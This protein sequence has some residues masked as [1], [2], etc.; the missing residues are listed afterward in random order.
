MA[1][2]RLTNAVV[3]RVF[4]A[5]TAE[6]SIYKARMFRSGVIALNPGVSALLNGGGK[7]FDLPFWQDVGG[8]S[9][10]V[11]SET[12]AATVNNLVAKQQTF[13]RQ[14][15]LKAW[16]TNDLVK[17]FAGDNPIEA[18]QNMVIEYWADAY[19]RIAMETIKGVLADNIANDASDLL[20]DVSA[21][22][23]AGGIFNSDAVI[24][25]QGKLGENGTVGRGDLNNGDYAAIIVHPLTYAVMRKQN[26]IDFIPIG[27]QSRPTA[28]YMGMQVI[29]D[30]HSPV[31]GANYDTII[32]KPG[33]L[34]FGQSVF[35][36]EPTE[37]DRAPGT[38]FGIDALYTRRVFG[39][40]PVGTQW[41]DHT[42]TD[43]VTPSDANLALAANWD[44]VYAKE[45]M[46]FVVLRHRVA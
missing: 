31:S 35:G 44:R 1:E 18:L 15:R 12:V 14:T 34:Q 9:G 45:N 43:N 19:D 13:R 6:E 4:T 10:D 46:H 30:R 25:A 3:P 36:Y 22:V 20:N 5:Y 21:V 33:A 11:P 42:V 26:A 41:L 27:D 17:V 32:A 38:G 39:I 2:T 24:D 8:T 29:V 37:L 40:H 23:G 28:F 16:G 7:I